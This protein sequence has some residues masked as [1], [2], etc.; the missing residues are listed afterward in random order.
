VFA[1]DSTLAY[2]LPGPA[3]RKHRLDFT[4]S[5]SEI[6]DVKAVPHVGAV[7]CAS[8]RQHPELDS[9]TKYYLR[10]RLVVVTGDLGHTW[11]QEN[12]PIS[13]K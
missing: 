11:F 13:G 1:A 8:E 12:L 5:Q 7:C 3:K 10:N 2:P 4:A 9:E 6:K